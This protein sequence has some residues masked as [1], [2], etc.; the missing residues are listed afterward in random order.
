MKNT[1]TLCLLLTCFT[2]SAQ[3]NVRAWYAQGQVW[4]I[5][6]SSVPGPETVGIF[7]KSTP[8]TQTG[9]ASLIGRPFNYEYFPGTYLMQTQDPDFTYRIPKP[10]GTYY[11]LLPGEGLF[12]ETV[13]STGS[14]YY[15]VVAWGQSTVTPGVNITASAVNFTYNPVTQ[16]V[17]CH[18]QRTE[19]LVS[20][21]KTFWFNMWALGRQDE[22][23]GRPDYPVLANAA[24]NGMPAMFIVSQS[25]NLDTSGGKKVP[26]T[27]LFHGGGGTA[28]QMM[29]NRFRQFNLEPIQGISVAHNDDFAVNTVTEAGDSLFTSG[30]SLWFGWSKRHN[31]FDHQ[32]AVMPGD[33]IINYTQ[34]RIMWINDW[35]IRVL[36]VDS[37]RVAVMGY[38]MGSGGAT[39]L[40]KT[41]PD[42]ISAACMF[43]AGFRGAEDPASVRI[44]GSKAQNLPTS[45]KGY[46]G[47]TIGVE[48]A[49]SLNVRCSHQ[50]DLPVMRVWI[51]KN[52]DNGRMHWGPEVSAQFRL[53]DSLGWGTQIHWDE[54]PHTYQVLNFHWI[55]GVNPDEQ[56]YRDNLSYQEYFRSNQSYPGFFNHRL[57][58]LNNDPGSGMIGINNGDGDNWGAWGGYHN[59]D[60]TTMLDE[61]GRWEV[62]AW[63]TA[64]AT[65]APDISPN[66]ALLTSM[67]IRKPQQF[68]P[69]PGTPLEWRVRD[70]SNDQIIQAGQVTP[71]ADGLI[72]VPKI[73]VTRENFRKIRIQ[74]YD[75]NLVSATEP[76]A[77]NLHLFP[78]PANTW[79]M[80]PEGV[81]WI[82]IFDGK[83]TLA[84]E[85]ADIV[86]QSLDLAGLPSGFYLVNSNLGTGKLLIRR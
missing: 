42:K 69:A 28:N 81:E 76:K 45:L 58:D 22:N 65:F 27:N 56:T 77:Q 40:A 84:L 64:E 38:S 78:N 46:N 71:D 29:A 32:F 44:M 33:T 83:G 8:F 4:I 20:G 54:R 7:K 49:F 16:R 75:P 57:E 3:T 74:V 63:L 48:E 37:N 26:M 30:R 79:L 13:L 55:E 1:L 41:F 53:A 67:T 24:K 10:D 18:L 15:A 61:P 14:A 35:L 62:T 12:V 73:F 43:N 21:H 23:A 36:P 66:A 6:D 47:E 60:L 80:L 5:W 51:G 19:T 17:N 82:R 50:R 9:Q 59:W 11:Q 70:V 72:T 34:R 68:K 86:A 25:L 39:L 85:R 31:P 52:D 2:L